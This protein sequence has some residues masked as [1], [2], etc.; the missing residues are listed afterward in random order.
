MRRLTTL[1]PSAFLEEHAEELGVVERYRKTQMPALVWSF[2]FGFAASESRTLAGFRCS[3][4]AT[5]DKTLSP[6]GFHQRLTPSFAEYLRDLVERGIDEVAVPDTVDV[7]IDRFRDMMIADGTVL[8]LH[9]YLSEEFEPRR[10]EQGGARLHL[11]HNVTDQTIDRFSVTDEKAHD[12][13]EFSTGSWLENRLMLFDQAYFRYRRFALIDENDGSFVSR[14][15]PNANPEIT[16]ELR[17]WRGDAIPLEGEKIQDVMDDLH[18]KYIDVEV[19]ATFQRR[20]YAGTQSWDSKRFCV[21]GVHDE[22]ADDYHLYIT[23]L[24][25]EE[26][27]PTDIATIYRCRWEVELL[28]RELKTQYGLDEFDTSKKHIVEILVYAALLSLLVSRDLLALVTEEA[29]DE[30]VFPPE[31]WAA[32]VRSHAQLILSDLGEFLGY[33]PPPLL[34]RLI[35]DAQK[36]HQQRPILQETLATATQPRCEA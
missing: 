32:T 16:A 18:R 8:R 21:V 5:A 9:R 29:D 34:D 15:K 14:L 35:E 20:E 10:G 33:S 25:R 7:D 19:E 23:N 30:I 26:F 4:N 28:F 36:T 17:E 13:T 27:F 24:P 12:S 31:R 6:G 2:V 1:F 11:L 22:D 3:Y